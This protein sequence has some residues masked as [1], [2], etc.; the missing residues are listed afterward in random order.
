MLRAHDDPS[1]VPLKEALRL[2]DAEPVID[3]E[4][5]ALGRWIS[6]YYCAPLGEVLRS[7]LPLATETRSGKNYWLRED[8]TRTLPGSYPFNPKRKMP[9]AA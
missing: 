4:L 3:E 7:M 6:G 1:D 9:P 8:R 2:I 5:L